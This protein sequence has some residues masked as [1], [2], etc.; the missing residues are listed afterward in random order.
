MKFLIQSLVFAIGCP[1]IA[2]VIAYYGGINP[3]QFF[4]FMNWIGICIIFNF[5]IRMKSNQ[6][7][8]DL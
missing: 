1:L 3:D 4:T 7:G 8:D 6:K 2:G 5:L